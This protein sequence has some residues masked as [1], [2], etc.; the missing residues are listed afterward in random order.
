[1]LGIDL[2][3]LL[4]WIGSITF[5]VCAAPQAWKS[6][7]DK[8]SDGLSGMFILLWWIGEVATL[9]YTVIGI[10][11]TNGALPLIVNYVLNMAFLAIITY[12]KIW[13]KK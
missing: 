10:T 9:I 2:I 1:M 3:S 6:W 4:G 12:Y 5:A 11:L 13:S 8:H 7:K